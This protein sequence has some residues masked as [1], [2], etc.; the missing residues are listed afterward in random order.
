MPP[1]VI[2]DFGARVKSQDIVSGVQDTSRE[3]QD[4]PRLFQSL[5]ASLNRGSASGFKTISEACTSGE[6]EV[7]I[8]TDMKRS[9]TT[10][11]PKTVL[12]N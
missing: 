4:P 9:E 6:E 2:W 1:T 8:A 11:D 10:F 5:S 3:W 12:S 7:S